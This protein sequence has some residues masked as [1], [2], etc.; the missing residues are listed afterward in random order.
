M[1]ILYTKLTGLPSRTFWWWSRTSTTNDAD[2]G[3]INVPVSSADMFITNM[4]Y[5]NRKESTYI[6]ILYTKLTGMPSRTSWWWSRTSTTDDADA[7]DENVPVGS[8]LSP[9]NHPI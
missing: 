6:D 8:I 2:A 5:L 1:D 3:D 9:R 7:G 4:K